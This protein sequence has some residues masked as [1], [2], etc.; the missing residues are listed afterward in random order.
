MRS[1]LPQEGDQVALLLSAELDSGDEVEEL[2]GVVERQQPPVVQVGRRILDAPE[3][4]RLDGTVGA[5]HLAVDH[6]RLVE[7]LDPEIVHRVVGVIRRGM[8]VSALR[9]AEEELLALQ[10]RL[11]RQRRIELPVE[12]ELRRRRE[13]EDLLEL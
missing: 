4:E 10:L 1:E 11:R 5:R 9:L 13:V 8:A 12:P 6:A 3:R 7:A 2:D